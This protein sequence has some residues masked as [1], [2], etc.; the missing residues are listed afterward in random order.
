[1]KQLVTITILITVLFVQSSFPI[2][3]ATPSPT[4]TEST[5]PTSAATNEKLNDKINDLKE[6]IAS[7]VSELNLVE[8]RGVIGTVTEVSGHKITLTDTTG[9][10]RIIDVDEITKFVSATSSK[11]T[12]GLSDITK[13]SKISVLGLYNKQSKRL[14]ARFVSI[15]VDPLFVSGTITTMD[16]K[17]F[18]ITITTA[19]Q[20]QTVVDILTSTTMQKYD[21]EAGLEKIGFSKLAAGTRVTVIGYPDKKDPALLAAQRLVDLSTLPTNPNISAPAQEATDSGS[22]TEQ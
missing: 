8:R 14:L 18:Q 21:A 5:T 22:L 2:F 12:F 19:D 16:K 3:A 11:S 10:T 4:E 1:M 20:K 15:T 13:G 9:K 17:N 6:K 7:R